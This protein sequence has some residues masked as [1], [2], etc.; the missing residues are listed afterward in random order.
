MNKYKNI[1]IKN[2]KQLYNF[3]LERYSKNLINE[4][5]TLNNQSKLKTDYIKKLFSLYDKYCDRYGNSDNVGGVIVG[6]LCYILHKWNN[7]GEPCDNNKTSKRVNNYI[8]NDT[9][10]TGYTDL[11][12]VSYNNYEKA[13]YKNIEIVIDYLDSH[14]ELFN[15]PNNGY[16][17][18]Q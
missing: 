11:T 5:L 18:L 8:L 17:T 4:K 3:I 2:M 16:F 15:K 7:D 10:V 1:K 6:G 9:Y 12:Q 13:L 14:D